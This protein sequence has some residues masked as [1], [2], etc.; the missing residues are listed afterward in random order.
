MDSEAE[1]AVEGGRENGGSEPFSVTLPYS[2]GADDHP[3][4]FLWLI[5]RGP[6]GAEELV[7]FL[8]DTG[9]DFSVLPLG[10]ASLLGYEPEELTLEEGNQVKGKVSFFRPADPMRAILPG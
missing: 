2:T 4:P 9:A 8:I 7:Q 6:R 5:V 3:R 1:D 10:Y